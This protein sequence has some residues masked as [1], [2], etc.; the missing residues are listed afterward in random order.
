MSAHR[1]EPKP[2][3]RRGVKRAKAAY[4]QRIRERF[5]SSDLSM[6]RGIKCIT[7]YNTRDSQFP[8]DPS[9]LDALNNSYFKDSIASPSTR[10]TTPPGEESLSVIPAEVRRTSLEG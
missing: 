7:D 4:A 2:A 3:R 6:W 5:T 1:V 10:L 8:R 9:L